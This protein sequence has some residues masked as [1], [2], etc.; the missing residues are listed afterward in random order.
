MKKIFWW[1]FIIACLGFAAYRLSVVTPQW[2]SVN[3]AFAHGKILMAKISKDSR[4]ANVK[5]Y[6][7]SHSPKGYIIVSG[8]V[9]SKA[10]ASA[11]RDLITASQ[12]PV[13]VRAFIQVGT[14]WS[15]KPLSKPDWVVVPENE[16]TREQGHP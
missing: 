1:I 11:L 15:P 2:R 4:F 14:A 12:P 6:G 7:Q 13:S 10:D 5:I 8:A 9:H 16:R 3:A